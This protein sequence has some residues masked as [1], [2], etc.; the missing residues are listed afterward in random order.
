MSKSIPAF[1]LLASAI[2]APTAMS[3]VVQDEP[4]EIPSGGG[5]GTTGPA[6]EVYYPYRDTSIRFGENCS[7]W[8]S[9]ELFGWADTSPAATHGLLLDQSFDPQNPAAIQGWNQLNQDF[10]VEFGYFLRREAR[11]GVE[12]PSLLYVGYWEGQ[13]VSS[14]TGSAESVYVWGLY[15]EFMQ[16]GNRVVTIIPSM[17]RINQSDAADEHDTLMEIGSQ[18]DVRT[19]PVCANLDALALGQQ[20]L[21]QIAADANQENCAAHFLTIEAGCGLLATSCFATFG[22]TC[23]ISA[24]CYLTTLMD[25]ARCALE[26]KIEWKRAERCLCFE[27]NW[28]ANNPGQTYPYA[29]CGAYSPVRCPNPLLLLFQ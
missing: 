16:D 18:F 15:F 12:D 28:R 24:G 7:Q 2:F 21:N 20:A 3:Q 29:L 13:L 1:A 14:H 5:V 9:Q 10:V 17:A 25:G 11:A 22:T 26:I 19:G 8:V 27:S 6:T 4:I 23:I